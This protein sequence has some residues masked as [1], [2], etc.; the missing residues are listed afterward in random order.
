ML[1]TVDIYKDRWSAALKREWSG[2]GH[3]PR[4]NWSAPS[5]L[6]DKAIKEL[7]VEYKREK[8]DPSSGKLLGTYWHRP[9]N[10]RQE[11]WDL[12]VYST[13]ALEWWPSTYVSNASDL[14]I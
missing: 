8:R 9:G 13:C 6:P 7:T 12:L 11:L 14:S 4:N 10:A 1:A 5:D 2:V 3:M